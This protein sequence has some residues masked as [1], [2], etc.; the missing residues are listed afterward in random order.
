MAKPLSPKPTAY[1][2]PELLQ[3]IQ[4]L[5][6]LEL[7][8][9]TTAAAKALGLSQP[10]VSRRARHLVRDLDLKSNPDLH[11]RA[12]RYG[13]SSCLQ[14]LRRACQAHRLEAGA[15]RVGSCPWHQGKV[16]VSYLASKSMISSWKPPI[17]AQR[18]SRSTA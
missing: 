4:L 12:L 14:L 13:G 11:E 10:T 17:K 7:G 6:L 3:P 8:G 1:R 2:T 18:V 9:T 5:D 16:G 15:W